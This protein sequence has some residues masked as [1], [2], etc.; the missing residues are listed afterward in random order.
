MDP[1]LIE[2]LDHGRVRLLSSAPQGRFDEL[3]D[4]DGFLA[5]MDRVAG[6]LD[7]Y[8]TAPTWFS[9]TVRDDGL[10][11]AY[12][13]MEFGIH[14]SVPVYS[15][16]LGVLAGDH[17]QSAGDLHTRIQQEIVLGIGGFRA[18]RALGQEPTVC[19]MNEGHAAF[20]GLERI[21]VLREERKLDFATATEAVKAGTCF[22]THTPV[23]AG[24]DA[25]PPQM[26]DQY[27]GG[28][29]NQLGID[30]QQFL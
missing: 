22:T 21:R 10:R 8:L 24:N 19:H 7:H 28:Y 12:F 27:L 4:D 14:E 3:A 25:F 11:V 1:D 29:V 18:L 13:S 17:L 30:R 26:I 5:H 16:G 23:P 15:G 2:A 6:A 9:E 20:V